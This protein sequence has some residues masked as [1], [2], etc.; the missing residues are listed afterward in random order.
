MQWITIFLV[1]FVVI[2]LFLPKLQAVSAEEGSRLI[3]QG[4][5]LMDVRTVGEFQEASVPGSVNFPLQELESR[6]QAADIGKDETILVFCRSGNRSGSAKSLLTK[7]GY[8]SVK[9]LGAFGNA[10]KAAELS[11]KPEE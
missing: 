1:A 5:H 11:Q 10:M 2:F 3:Q 7:L 4:A 8:T 9:N 6:F